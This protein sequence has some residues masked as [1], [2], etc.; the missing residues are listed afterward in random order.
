MTLKI[1]IKYIY[2]ITIIIINANNDLLPVLGERYFSAY[3]LRYI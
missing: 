1:K 2:I 3:D